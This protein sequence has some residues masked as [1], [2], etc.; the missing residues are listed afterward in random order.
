[1]LDS[2]AIQYCL[3]YGSSFINEQGKAFNTYGM[4]ANGLKVADAGQIPK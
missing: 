3:D 1:M 4:V 2:G